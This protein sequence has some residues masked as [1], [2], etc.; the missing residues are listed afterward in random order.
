MAHIA[1]RIANAA[2]RRFD[3]AWLLT[4][5]IYIDGTMAM[6]CFDILDSAQE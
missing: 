5:A 4:N 1:R 2:W 3:N 6:R